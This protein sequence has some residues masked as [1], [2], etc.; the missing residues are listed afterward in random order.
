MI[1]CRQLLPCPEDCPSRMYSLMMECWHE[2]PVRRPHFPE[3]HARLRQWM[4]STP[5]QAPSSDRTNSTQLSRPPHQLIVRL[6]PPY[7]KPTT[8]IW[9]YSVI[10]ELW[11]IGFDKGFWYNKVVC[12]IFLMIVWFFLNSDITWKTGSQ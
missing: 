9:E 2:A 1:R 4:G 10:S 5:P 8:N 11:P 7:N 6:P 12:D 3:I